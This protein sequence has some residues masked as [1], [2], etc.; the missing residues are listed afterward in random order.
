MAAKDVTDRLRD[1]FPGPEKY[2]S[3]DSRG[4]RAQ[5]SS[6]A[7]ANAVRSGM[8]EVYSRAV[9]SLSVDDSA[10]CDDAFALGRRE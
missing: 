3:T 8:S 6:R 1:L 7:G 10:T 4:V 9:F 2:W 5:G